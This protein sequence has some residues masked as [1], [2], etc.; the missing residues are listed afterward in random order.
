MHK[1]YNEEKGPQTCI[2]D[3]LLLILEEKQLLSRE[4]I[5]ARCNHVVIQ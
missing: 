1:N 2:G 3:R 5:G 4:K